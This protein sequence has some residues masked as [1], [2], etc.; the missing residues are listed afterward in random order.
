MTK[1]RKFSGR[2][3]G[4]GQWRGCPGGTR[5]VHWPHPLHL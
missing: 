1:C 4:W 3:W 5:P 2:D